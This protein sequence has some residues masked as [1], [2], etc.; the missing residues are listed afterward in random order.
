MVEAM[1]CESLFQEVPTGLLAQVTDFLSPF[2]SL[3][4]TISPND[5]AVF[6]LHDFPSSS[7]QFCAP[8]SPLLVLLMSF[9]SPQTV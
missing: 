1:T 6:Q 4:Y 5:S 8:I 3:S 2:L 7:S 9:S